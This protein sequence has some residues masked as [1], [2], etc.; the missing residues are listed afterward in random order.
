MQRIPVARGETNCG[1]FP[2]KNVIFT[3]TVTKSEIKYKIMIFFLKGGCTNS[4]C[5]IE[6]YICLK[7]HI[8]KILWEKMK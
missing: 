7:K 1:L 4:F 3:E 5:S 6:Q 8:P 2:V